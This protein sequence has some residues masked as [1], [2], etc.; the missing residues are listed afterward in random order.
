MKYK[1]F[2]S[3]FFCLAF[4][5]VFA[6]S[7]IIYIST[8]NNPL[9]VL[10]ELRVSEAQ[11]SDAEIV[12]LGDSSLGA[13][14]DKNYFAELTNGIKVANLSTSADA[15]NLSCTYNLLRH[16]IENNK[17]VKLIVIMQT[18]M[19]WYK[20]FVLGGYCSTLSGLDFG[21]EIDYHLVDKTDCFKFHYSNLS[22]ILESATMRRRQA[23]NITD[24]RTYRNGGRDIKK[25]LSDGMHSHI[26]KIGNTKQLEVELIDGYASGLNAKVVYVQSTLHAEIAKQYSDVIAKQ[27]QILK[28]MKNIAFIEKYLYP[29][30]K[31]MGDTENHVDDSY[32]KTSTEFYFSILKPY[33]DAIHD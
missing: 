15:H 21:K 19:V 31:N 11:N 2:I 30:N 25:E 6:I 3:L 16:T 14:I 13:C 33:I 5:I 23:T 24:T 18:P 10:S 1:K 9:Y 26:K 27:Q 8:I 12:F 22:A 29:E 17:N 32:R 28:G 4:S 20:D 7:Q